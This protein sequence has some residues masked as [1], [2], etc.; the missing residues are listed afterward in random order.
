MVARAY[1]VAFHGVEARIVEV[2]CAVTPGMPAFA[3]VGLPVNRRA[4]RE[5]IAA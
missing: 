2:Q 4:K 3:I 5:P 1:T